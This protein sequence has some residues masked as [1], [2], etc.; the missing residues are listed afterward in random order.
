ML[1]TR[2]AEYYGDD[3]TL[4]ASSSASTPGG[5]LFV[6]DWSERSRL[7]RTL[8]TVDREGTV[9]EQSAMDLLRPERLVFIYERLM[10]V[11]LALVP[12]PEEILLLGLGGGAMVRHLA[13]Y[14]PECA[15]TVVERDPAVIRLARR[16]FHLVQPVICGNAEDVVADRAGAFDVVMIDLYDSSGVVALADVFWN[17]CRAALRP[18]GC[19]AINWAG[20]VEQNQVEESIARLQRV[21]GPSYFLLDQGLRPNLVQLVPTAPGQRPERL[22]RQLADFASGARLPREDREVLRRSHV[23]TRFSRQRS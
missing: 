2:I 13:A 3:C 9:L 23:S 4:I 18:G 6:V 7:L 8:G 19:L 22:S 21:V 14:L 12:A 1:K 16:H 15:I 5:R 11:S 20:F 17:D 10:L